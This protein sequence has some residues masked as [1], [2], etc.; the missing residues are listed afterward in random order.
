[1]KMAWARTL[2]VA[3]VAVAACGKS[4]SGTTGDAG[5]TGPTD[6]VAKWTFTGKAASAA[7]CTAH[8][9]QQVFVTLSGTI[10][11]S[12]HKTATADCTKGTV[13]LGTFQVED[14]GA[15]YLE[16]ALLDDMGVQV[17]IVG[18]NVTPV[19]GK[20]TVT[21]DFFPAP[22]GTGGSTS[23]SVASSVAASSAASSGGGGAGGMMTT[24][25]TSATT[26]GAGGGP[27]AGSDGG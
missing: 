14:L 5:V 6:V 9:G 11:S 1:M 25:S 19:L 20:T 23:S 18:V 13:D 26:G 17:A 15:P 27:D 2:L 3:L 4:S 21:L 24:S 7:E 16:A 10:D 12:L 22:M 8:M